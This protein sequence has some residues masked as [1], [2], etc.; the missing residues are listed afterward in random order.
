MDMTKEPASNDEDSRE[1]QEALRYGLAF[2]DC[3]EQE[4]G[5]LFGFVIHILLNFLFARLVPYHIP[6]RDVFV[7][8]SNAVSVRLK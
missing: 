4:Y 1:Q 8:H 5:F 2:R 7:S 6:V 3:I